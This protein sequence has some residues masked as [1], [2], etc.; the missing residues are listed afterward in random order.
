[1]SAQSDLM[2]LPL[3][4]MAVLA[5]LWWVFRTYGRR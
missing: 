1:M 5:G 4:V 2:Y 3:V